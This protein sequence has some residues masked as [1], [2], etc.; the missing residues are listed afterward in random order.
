MKGNPVVSALAL[1]LLAVGLA[2]PAVAGEGSVGV[3]AEVVSQYV[4]RG[5]VLDDGWAVQPD[6]VFGYAFD[7]RTGLEL[8]AW[9]NLALEGK[10][11]ETRQDELFEQDLTLAFTH[12]VS[13]AVGLQ[14]GTIYYW[15]PFSGVDPGS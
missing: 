13:E 14:A 6:L 12:Q 3:D 2:R 4:W 15:L 9:W 1:L 5:V 7:D 11:S 10:G 8:A